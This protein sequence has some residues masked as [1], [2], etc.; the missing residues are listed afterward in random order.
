MMYSHP[1]E[2]KENTKIDMFQTK[3]CY[4]EVGDIMINKI[5]IYMKQAA[6]GL[7]AILIYIVFP[8]F[9]QIPL[10][11]FDI[12]VATMPLTMKVIYLIAC[13]IL[14][15]AILCLVFYK[16]LK[17]DIDDIKKN[18]MEYFSKYFKF[19]L[20]GLLLMMIG[21]MIAM[22][23]TGSNASGNQTDILNTFQISPIYIF[24]MGVICAPII[25]EFIFRKAIRNIIPHKILYIVLSGLIFG[26]C[27]LI[28]NMNSWLDLLYLL[29]YCPL[30][31]VFAYIYA[32]TNNILVSMGLHFM[33]NGILIALQFIILLFG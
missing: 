32:N 27:H 7:L 9:E 22:F 24:V 16:S 17:N 14:L 18:H 11:L 25:E 26:G 13:E 5:Q 12:D 15:A 3:L 23:G 4:N 29:G 10:V 1:L 6:I 8:I 33:H 31:F 2:E 20:L 28:G 19:Y 30:G 21:N